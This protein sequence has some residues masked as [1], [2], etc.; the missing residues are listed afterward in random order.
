VDAKTVQAIAADF[1]HRFRIDRCLVIGDSGLLSADNAAE[2]TRL[3]LGYLLGL[4]A[5][6]NK[7]AKQ[8]IAATHHLEPAGQMGDVTYWP[9]QVRG[10][11]AYIVLHSPG[12]HA[13]TL[14]IARRKLE[15]V[16]PKLQ[17][18]ERDV[19]SHKVRA[20]ATIAGRVTRILVEAK[21]TPYIEY[22]VSEGQFSWSERAEKLKAL[23]IDAG[24]Y[25]LQTNQVN[26]DAQQAVTAYRQLEVVEDDFRRL[27]DTLHLRPVYHRNPQRVKG[28]VGLCVIA[29]FLLRLLEQRLLAAGICLPAEQAI[30]AVQDLQAV[31]IHVAGGETWP[32]AIWPLPHI[33]PTA[34][35]IFRAVGVADPKAQFRTDV[36]SL[37]TATAN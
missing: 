29:L 25:V 31:P 30:A 20:A 11:T 16:R 1:R 12:R 2:L 32:D 15:A 18:L 4:R 9:T 26:L 10:D 3:G 37:A 8:V 5:A 36:A 23:A 22:E 13:K 28:H 14:A 27:K 35:A 19:R 24:K 33:S 21:A 34:A 6:N 17:Q 7:T